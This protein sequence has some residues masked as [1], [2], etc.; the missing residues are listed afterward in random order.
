MLA[1][2]LTFIFT[3]VSSHLYIQ[4]LL[5]VRPPLSPRTCLSLSSR[6]RNFVAHHVFRVGSPAEWQSRRRRSQSLQFPD[7]SDIHHACQIRP[8]TPS[9]ISIL[10]RLQLT[11]RPTE[12]RPASR[13]SLQAQ[14][15]IRPASNLP[16]ATPKTAPRPPRLPPDAH[17][18]RSM[19]KPPARPANAALLG[20]VSR[21][22]CHL[23]LL[24]VRW[25]PCG[26]GPVSPSLL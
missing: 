18:Q 2:S 25:L 8:S 6:Q 19:E 21:R 5:H 24:S 15:R 16:R 26:N 17:H 23:H 1:S 12:R 3:A 10:Q 14:Q 9:K 4:V 11:L 7:T 20:L 22:H 13:T